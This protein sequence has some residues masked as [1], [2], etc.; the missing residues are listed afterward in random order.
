MIQQIRYAFGSLL[1]VLLT[2]TSLNAQEYLAA[3]NQN[4]KWGYVNTSCEFVIEPIYQKAKSFKE[5][6]Y[7]VVQKGEKW[8]AIDAQGNVVVEIK[9]TDI[10]HFNNGMFAVKMGDRWGYV[11]ASGNLVIET[12]YARAKKFD[13][14][15]GELV[16]EAKY[17]IPK[18]GGMFGSQFIVKKGFVLPNIA[19]VKDGKNWT[20]INRKGEN[21]CPAFTNA[22]AF[23]EIK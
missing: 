10:G 15:S 11:D 17:G 2:I 13:N 14:E 20:Y 22:E 12:K 16:M 8:G 18:S 5:N 6:K 7:A 9:Y 23:V 1:I 19:R 4:G 21:V 3:V